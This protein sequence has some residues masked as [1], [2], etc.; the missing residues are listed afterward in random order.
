MSSVGIVALYAG[1]C[2]LIGFVLALLVSRQRGRAKVDIGSGGDPGVERAMRAHANFVEYVPLI[3]LLMLIL[4][5]DR[6][7]PWVLH[8]MGI[9]LVIGRILH[10]WGLSAAVSI[11]RSLGIVLTWLV[12]L[13]AA[14]IAIV[15]GVGAVFVELAAG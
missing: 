7:Q 4:E 15:Q 6:T 11:G 5:I 9:A 8:L 1:L 14:I 10:G 2:A 12:L 3:L 13:A